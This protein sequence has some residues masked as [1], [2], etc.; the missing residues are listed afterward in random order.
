MPFGRRNADYIS[1]CLSFSR[2]SFHP[3]VEHKLARRGVSF[4]DG[5]IACTSHEIESSLVCPETLLEYRKHDF[6]G[7]IVMERPML[8]RSQHIQ[9][10]LCGR[11][12]GRVDDGARN[13][14]YHPPMVEL[15]LNGTLSTLELLALAT[16]RLEQANSSQVNVS[17][18]ERDTQMF[19]ECKLLE[20]QDEPVPFAFVI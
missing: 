2:S 6:I 9:C 10:R 11:W 13:N 14:V 3:D 20:L 7:V 4:A 8:V 16:P 1:L 5:I 12:W 19:L 15:G 18:D 17:G